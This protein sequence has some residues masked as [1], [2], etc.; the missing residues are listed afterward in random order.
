NV[1]LAAALGGATGDGQQDRIVVNATNGDDTITVS[2]DAAG[3]EVRGL[4]A[5]VGIFKSE[6]ATDRLEVNTL[7]GTDTV[8]SGGLVAGV[9]QLFVDG[10]LVP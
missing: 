2:G 6:A 9:I 5:K 1:D 10:V 3:V 7:A 4:V 8:D